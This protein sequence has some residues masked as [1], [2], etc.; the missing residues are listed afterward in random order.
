M[1]FFLLFSPFARRQRC[2]REEKKN[3]FMIPAD[4]DSHSETIHTVF[5]L[6]ISSSS[7]GEEKERKESAKVRTG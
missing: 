6:N 1:D 2:A 7:A 5:L 3:S 4:V